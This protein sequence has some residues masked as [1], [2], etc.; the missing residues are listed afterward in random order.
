M[1]KTILI[2]PD[3]REVSSG[4]TAREAILSCKLTQCVNSGQELTLGSVCAAMA[5]IKILTPNGDLPI[6][7][8]DELT[9]YKQEGSTRRLV[10]IFI[11]EKPQRPNAHILKLTAYD[12]VSL[13]DQDMSEWLQSL[14]GWP[15]SLYDF[16]Q[17]VCTACGVSLKNEQLPNGSYLVQ[18]FAARGITGRK[19]L[20]WAAQAAGRFCRATA[21]G[22]LEFA[23]YEVL[24]GITVGPFAGSAQGSAHTESAGALTLA[25]V[26][27]AESAGVLTLTGVSAT[28]EGGVLTLTLAGGQRYYYEGGLSFADYAVAPIEKVQLQQNSDDVGVVYPP[29]ATGNTYRITGNLLLTDQRPEALL[30]VAQTLYEQLKE[31][32]YTPCTLTLPASWD[33]RPGHILQVADRCGKVFS[34]YLMA[35]TQTAGRMTLES[36]GSSSR[37]STSAQNERSYEALSG[38]V[39]NLRTDVEGIR[40]ENKN[41]DGRVAALSLTVDGLSAQVQKQTIEADNLRTQLTALEQTA[42]AVKISV[43]SMEENGAAKVKTAASYTFD[44]QGLR[45]AKVGQQMENLLDNT[46]MYVSR[47]G[48]TILQANADG[49]GAADVRVRNYLCIG[50]H[51]R[52]EDYESGRTACF[53]IGG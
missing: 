30:P 8:E 14:T 46:G 27:A 2:L 26:T 6:R 50:D 18:K 13:L 33:I 38:Q 1:E 22:E 32:T 49:V 31:V 51:A 52:L 41:A 3:G 16:A 17:M 5:E 21:E 45:I 36:T 53:F 7:A 39:L 29:D 9:V 15:Y 35:K 48:E 12:R 34:T 24:P 47:S 20:S 11:A 44:D 4:P 19:L 43:Q 10:G 40:A 23:W 37:E 25:G 42:N 28:E